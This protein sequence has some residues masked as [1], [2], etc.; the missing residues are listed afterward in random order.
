MIFLEKKTDCIWSITYVAAHSNLSYVKIKLRRIYIQPEQFPKKEN[1]VPIDAMD[2]FIQNFET[3]DD[4]MLQFY[5]T[6]YL[7]ALKDKE[8]QETRGTLRFPHPDKVF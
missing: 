2:N 5:H 6:D 4:E 1:K 7:A 3:L 8:Y